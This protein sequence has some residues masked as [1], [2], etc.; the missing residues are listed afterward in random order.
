M[1][2]V[3]ALIP[4]AAW[5]WIAI[6]GVA[7]AAAGLA[8]VKGEIAGAGRVQ[9]RWD[10]AI[11]AQQPQAAALA[12]TQ[13]TALRQ[14]DQTFEDQER[15]DAPIVADVRAGVLRQCAG[16]MRQPAADAHHPAAV[17]AGPSGAPTAPGPAPADPGPAIAHDASL[18]RSCAAQLNA[19]IDAAAAAGADQ[20]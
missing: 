3:L 2:T 4:T 16:G 7:L 8:W 12:K 17:P 13:A 18:Y 19:L 5:R 6:A 20:P 15:H 14:V 11:A 10:S 9:A 1:P